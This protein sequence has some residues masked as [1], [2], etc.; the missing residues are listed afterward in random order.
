MRQDNKTTCYFFIFLQKII[1]D[2]NSVWKKQMTFF[3]AMCVSV[4]YGY[5]M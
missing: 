4:K 5:T 1:T 3:E 2:C